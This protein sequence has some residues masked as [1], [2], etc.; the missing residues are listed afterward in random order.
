MASSDVAILAAGTASSPLDY[1]VPN[2]QEIIPLA[3]T[4]TVNGTGAAGAFIP[5]LEI[6]GAGGVVIAR[7]P[8]GST[9]AAGASVDASW[10][11]H[12]GSVVSGTSTL[13]INPAFSGNTIVPTALIVGTRATQPAPAAFGAGTIHTGYRTIITR[14]GTLHDLGVYIGTGG[15]SVEVAILSTDTPTRQILYKTGY[16]ATPNSHTWQIIGDP[17]LAVQVGEQYD[18]AVSTSGTT[19]TLMWFGGLVNSGATDAASGILP[20]SFVPAPLGAPPKL[21]WQDSTSPRPYGGTTTV[22]EASLTGQVGC[23][24]VIGRIV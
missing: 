15:N 22:A 17:N 6:I 7:C 16:V 23:P 14:A 1:D 11:P 24:I 8:L 13:P 10:F 19:V 3:V 4:A 5:T 12:V 18:I 9:I 21:V 20:A 2:A